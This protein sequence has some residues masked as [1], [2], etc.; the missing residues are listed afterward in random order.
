MILSFPIPERK[1]RGS[2]KREREG[3]GERKKRGSEKREMEGKLR[4]SEKREGREN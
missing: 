4:E 2:E 3:R 1:R